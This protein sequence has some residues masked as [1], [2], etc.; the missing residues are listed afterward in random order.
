MISL[1][2]GLVGRDFDLGTRVVTPSAIRDYAESVGDLEL[3]RG[4]CDQAPAGFALA[5]RGGPT[6]AVE[7]AAD[8][9]SVH[10]GHSIEMRR[11]LLA[12]GS[13]RLR[14]RIADVFEKN[15]RSGPLTVITRHAEIVDADDV[16]CVAIEDQQIVRWRPPT[17]AG[18]HAAQPSAVADDIA[19]AR[20]ADGMIEDPPEV[21]TLVGAEQQA[22]P[23]PLAVDRYAR[24][25]AGAEPLFVDS[26]YARTL[27][28][29]DV[30]V[31]G[32]LQSA[33]LERMLRRRLPRWRLYGL[34]LSFRVSVI[35]AE[36][37]LLGAIVVEH[38]LQPTAESLICDL[39]IESGASDRAAIGTA[40][41]HR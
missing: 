16:C 26:D 39:W 41:L 24:R 27:G 5:L 34:S 15:G 38:H 4:A 2:P 31:P 36:P 29:G 37:I 23:D 1:P 6:P 13:Y 40:E 7:L 20:S 17:S 28:Y 35:A 12:P 18:V 10:A 14:S 3:A 21:G 8:T 33:L 19:V 25:L 9:V 22:A 30:I 11:G 32:P